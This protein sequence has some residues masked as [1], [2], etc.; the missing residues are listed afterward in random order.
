MLVQNQS[1]KVAK[2]KKNKI[3]ISLKKKQ[4]NNKQKR[5]SK[6]KKLKRTSKKYIRTGGMNFL[7]N[8]V[9]PRETSSVLYTGESIFNSETQLT[10]FSPLKF[11]GLPEEDKNIKKIAFIKDDT[12]YTLM[13]IT[14]TNNGYVF[15]VNNGKLARFGEEFKELTRIRSWSLRKEASAGGRA[16]DMVMGKNLTLILTND[17]CVFGVGNPSFLGWDYSGDLFLKPHEWSQIWNSK[18]RVSD[19]YPYSQDIQDS[20]DYGALHLARAANG[21]LYEPRPKLVSKTNLNT[22]AKPRVAQQVVIGEEH[23]MI[24]MTDKTV[25]VAG[26]NSRGQLGVGESG[27]VPSGK[28]ILLNDLIKRGIKVKQIATAGYTS[29]ILDEIGNVY[30]CGANN[31]FQTGLSNN[32]PGQTQTNDV[33]EFTKVDVT[34]EDRTHVRVTQIA[35]GNTHTMLLT[36]YGQVY[37]C[38]T[39]NEG[40]LGLGLGLLPEEQKVQQFKKLKLIPG[41]TCIKIFNSNTGT[42]ILTSEYKMFACGSNEKGNLGLPKKENYYVFTEVTSFDDIF[43]HFKI[44]IGSIIE[45]IIGTIKRNVLSKTKELTNLVKYWSDTVD[46]DNVSPK[47][48]KDKLNA[49]PPFEPN[50]FL[51]DFFSGKRYEEAYSSIIGS[52]LKEYIE[53]RIYMGDETTLI[54]SGKDE[55]DIEDIKNKIEKELKCHMMSE[56]QVFRIIEFL[57]DDEEDDQKEELETKKEEFKS[58]FSDCD[59]FKQVFGITP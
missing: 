24:L 36:E 20:Q 9:S 58:L 22:E 28:V 27:I 1:S 48:L 42:M 4:K 15:G 49:L 10:K 32:E 53:K 5:S 16:K 33:K 52:V 35:M 56:P 18:A 41:M 40:Q 7:R 29:F 34:Q 30:S 46:P 57:K 59:D 13:L 19:A 45:S 37:I 43:G 17:G 54:L 14:S 26:K 8:V 6:K 11:P 12:G 25:W 55:S 2:R 50:S 21:Y 39:G 23:L 38:G 3:N 51:E 44:E 47:D 31:A